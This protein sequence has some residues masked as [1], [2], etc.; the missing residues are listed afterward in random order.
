MFATGSAVPNERAQLLLQ[1][2]APVLAQA[3]AGHLDR[4]PYR[5][6]A[7]PGPGRTNWE[8][9]S[10]ACQCDAPAADRGG[11]AGSRIRSVTGNADRDPLLPGDPLAAANRRIAIVVLRSCR[12]AP[13]SPPPVIARAM[14]APAF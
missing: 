10:R 13:R 11:L 3:A 1:K 9:S 12:P 8:L 2:V 4:R 14:I 6:G 7:I 5:R